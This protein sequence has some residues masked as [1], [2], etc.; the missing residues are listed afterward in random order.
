[1]CR[2]SKDWTTVSY[3]WISRAARRSGASRSSNRCPSGVGLP[4]ATKKRSTVS[5]GFVSA[6]DFSTISSQPRR[7]PRDLYAANMTGNVE[8]LPL[9]LSLSFSHSLGTGYNA[10]RVK[11]GSQATEKTKT[12][13]KVALFLRNHLR[14][15]DDTATVR[16][17]IYV[18]IRERLYKFLS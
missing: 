17:G 15:C 1:M 13:R 8:C 5:C 7:Y 11:S 3:S 16:T 2:R 4:V 14:I 18:C 6:L 10:Y 9:F 12:M